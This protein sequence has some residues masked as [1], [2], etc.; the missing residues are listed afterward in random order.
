MGFDLGEK[1]AKADV[2]SQG[3]TSVVPQDA[4]EQHFRGFSP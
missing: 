4:I 1:L 2:M 3:T